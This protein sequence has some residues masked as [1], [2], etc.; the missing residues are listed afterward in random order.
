MSVQ[1]SIVIF[2]HNFD[3]IRKSRSHRLTVKI[4][5]ID[6]NFQNTLCEF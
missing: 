3:V 5:K 1:M 6:K 4:S 2:K